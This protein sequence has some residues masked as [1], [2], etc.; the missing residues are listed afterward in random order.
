VHSFALSRREWGLRD[1]ASPLN[2]LR[3]EL[4]QTAG[5]AVPA[6]VVSLWIIQGTASCDRHRRHAKCRRA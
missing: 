3:F 6:D 5:I 4:R 1:D 2:F